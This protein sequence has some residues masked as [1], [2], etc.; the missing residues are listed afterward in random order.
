MRA[1]SA[2]VDGYHLRVMIERMQREGRSEREIVKAVDEATGKPAM[3][4]RR[5]TRRWPARLT[6]A[7][8]G[9]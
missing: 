2:T 4:A 8:R 5:E 6:R 1:S 3:R 9:I 7:R